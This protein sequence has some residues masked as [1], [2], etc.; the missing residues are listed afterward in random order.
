MLD[1]AH[2]SGQVLPLLPGAGPSRAIITSR[3][4]LRGLV[5]SGAQVLPLDLLDRGESERFLRSRLRDGRVD[6]EPAGA[7]ALIEISGGLPLALS[8]LAARSAHSASVPLSAIA[9]AVRSADASLDAFSDRADPR[10]S[11][12]A[13]LSWSYASLTTDAARL[14][15]LLAVHPSPGVPVDEAAAAAGLA[16]PATR[17]L[18]DEL[19]EANIAA[20]RA[21]GRIWRHDLLRQYS[22]GLLA[23]AAPPARDQAERRLYEHV[24]SRAIAAASVLTPGRISLPGMPEGQLPVSPGPQ[25]VSEAAGWFDDEYETIISLVTQAPPSGRYDTCAWQLA[26]A[27]GHYLDRRGLWRESRTVHKAGL[28][29]ARRSGNIPAGAA[30]RL[31]IARAES[32]LGRLACAA[33]ETRSALRALTAWPDADPLFVSELHRELCWILDRQ[34]D[35]QGA[36]REARRALDLHPGDSRTIGRAFAL[37]AV[38]FCEARLELYDEALAHCTTAAQLLEQTAHRHGEGTVWDSLGFIYARTGNL[39]QAARSYERAIGLFRSAGSRFEEADSS[40]ALGLF[41]M[42]AGH[43]ADARPFLQTAQS[44]FGEL[45]LDQSGIAGDA[46]VRLDTA[47]APGR[48]V[49]Q[50]SAEGHSAQGGGAGAGD[51]SP[52][53]F[54]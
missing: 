47:K 11:I 5:A 24:T 40:L 13:V 32:Y 12:R 7:G 10:T 43:P 8:L 27:L 20:E 49:Q 16:I 46:L 14:F 18:M 6:A 28:E 30:M 15:T 2:D 19:V 50:A 52:G 42:N 41:L 34:G 53:A 45:G 17:A 29:A 23:G 39:R 26:R 3:R 25:A 33:H 1:N 38:G 51:R 48:R 36:L 37:N 54:G 22:A 4:Q 31:G 9:A 21:G 35:L 44:V